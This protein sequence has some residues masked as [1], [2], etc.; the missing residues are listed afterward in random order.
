MKTL[1]RLQIQA[2]RSSPWLAGAA[3]AWFILFLVVPLFIVAVYSLGLRGTYGGVTFS[4]GL[5]PENYARILDPIYFGVFLRS[6]GLSMMTS[7]SCLLIGYPMAYVMATARKRYRNLLMVLVVIPFWTN[8][9]VRTY[10]LKAA[11]AENGPVNR[12]LIA[13]GWL[14]EPFVFSGTTFAVWLGMVTNYLPFM[15]LP[16][17]VALE[18][19]DFTLLEAAGDLGASPTTRFFRILLPL[20]R[21]GVVTGLIFV[22]APALGE[23]VIPDLLGGAKTLLVGNLITDQFLKVRDWPFGAALSLVLIALVCIS[24]RVSFRSARS[25]S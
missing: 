21:R 11:L 10:A 6:L 17:Y 15:V 19:F 9:V 8:F 24:L 23:F 2:Y 25:A 20:T 22:F 4:A 1:T 12:W 7:V 5:T 16:L 13:A 3:F 14:H 18:K